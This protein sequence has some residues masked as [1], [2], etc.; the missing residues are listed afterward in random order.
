M[1][2]GRI[3]AL[4]PPYRPHAMV[5][6]TR[7][8]PLLTSSTRVWTQISWRRKRGEGPVVFK[9]HKMQLTDAVV[10]QHVDVIIKLVEAD[11]PL[12]YLTSSSSIEE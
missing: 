11:P 3:A 7:R 10:T 4:S 1:S 2:V 6:P 8:T 9:S 5:T 12:Y